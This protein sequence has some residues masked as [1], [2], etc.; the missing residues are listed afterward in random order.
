MSKTYHQLFYHIVWSTS[1]RQA[2]IT[3]DISEAVK[4]CIRAKCEELGCILRVIEM[5]SD[6]LH[7]L[8]T[9]PPSLSLSDFVMHVKGC[10]SHLVNHTIIPETPFHWQAGYSVMTISNHDRDRVSAYIRNQRA[11]HGSGQ[12]WPSLEE[13]EPE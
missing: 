5:V 6:H 4:R 7:M 3:E 11:H 1:G 12:V 10:S 8:V 2:V 9:I 13:T